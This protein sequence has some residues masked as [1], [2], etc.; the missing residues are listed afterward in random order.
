MNEPK[1]D[2]FHLIMFKTHEFSFPLFTNETFDSGPKAS[3][4]IGPNGTNKN[5]VLSLLIDELI[6]INELR[7]ELSSALRTRHFNGQV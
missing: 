6:I 3:V 7:S 5:R 1:V 2:N 4:L